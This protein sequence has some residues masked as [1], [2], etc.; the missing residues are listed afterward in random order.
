MQ[1]GAEGTGAAVL[2]QGERVDGG[3][4]LGGQAP[5]RVPDGL[6]VEGL[7]LKDG[8]RLLQ[9]V[10]CLLLGPAALR[11]GKPESLFHIVA[12]QAGIGTMRLLHAGCQGLFQGF[13]FGPC[14][15]PAGFIVEQRGLGHL[16]ADL[17][18]RVQ[19]GKGVLE[20]H[21]QL[22]AADI[23]EFR[24]RVFQQVL[25][26][27]DDF[28][29]LDDGVGGIDADDGFCRDGLAGAGFPHD[30]Q[31]FTLVQ[32][33]ADAAHGLH[34]AVVCVEGQAKILYL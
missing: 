27:V 14:V 21:G 22:V 10:H 2:A 8:Q 13:N 34:I 11:V 6:L 29:A 18:D 5:G 23:V 1:G 24:L 19:G 26:P 12:A 31:G 25:A 16:L 9:G 17:H 30:G 7:C 32:I 3:L 15:F 33:K 20:Y 4:H 28:A